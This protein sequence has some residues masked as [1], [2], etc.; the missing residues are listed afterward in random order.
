MCLGQ[1]LVLILEAMR[2]IAVA[3]S[4]VTPKLCLSIYGQLGYTEEQFNAATWVFSV[5]RH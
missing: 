3:L 1:D 5:S 2:I 4:P